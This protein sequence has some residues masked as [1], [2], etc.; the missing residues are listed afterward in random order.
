MS[1]CVL[2]LSFDPVDDEHA[3]SGDVQEAADDDQYERPAKVCVILSAVDYHADQREHR[4][5]TQKEKQFIEK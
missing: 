5:K 4:W 1:Q 2:C 3:A